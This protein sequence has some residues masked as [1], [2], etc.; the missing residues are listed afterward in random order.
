MNPILRLLADLE[1]VSEGKTRNPDSSGGG[2]PESRSPVGDVSLHDHFR[3]R[4]LGARTEQGLADAMNAAYEAL[5]V[6]RGGDGRIVPAGLHVEK[7]SLQW[8]RA[9][10]SDITSGVD[11]KLTLRLFDCSRSTYYRV[12]RDFCD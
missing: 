11:M 12:K 3:R 10:A 5:A 2:K 8:K 7:G 1:L 6:A 4:I 9:I